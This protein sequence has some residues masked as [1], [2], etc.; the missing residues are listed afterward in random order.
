[1][2]PQSNSNSCVR[3]AKSA[4]WMLPVL[5]L[6]LGAVALVPIGIRASD[7]ADPLNL[8]E[9]ESNI[10]D[11]FFFPKGDQMILILNVRRALLTAA[12]YNLTP[13]EYVVHMDFH[14]QLTFDSDEDRAR[15]GGTVV[16]PAG[17]RPDANLRFRL[18]NDTT[19][20]KTSFEGLTNPDRIRVYT[21]VR[22]DP[23]NFPRFFKRNAISMVMSIPLSSFPEGQ[24]DFILWGTTYKDGKQVDHVGRSNRTQ[25]VRFDP[26]N[27]LPPNEHVPEIMRLMK[28]RNDLFKFFND[29]KEWQPK[30]VAGL[31]QYVYQIRKYDVVPDVMVYTTRFEPKFPNGRQLL[32]DVAALTCQV[33]DCIL[34]E[35]SFIE[36][37]WPRALVNDKPFLADWPYLAEPYPDQPAMP[38]SMKSIW[39][40][41]IGL[42]LANLIVSWLIVEIIVRR[43]LVWLFRRKRAKA[44]A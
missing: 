25:L 8:K 6:L 33:G 14:S 5:I 16:N 1:M 38:Q 17:L 2:T 39:P 11:L 23:F 32:D 18:N 13:F 9:P 10:T 4:R 43:P 31:I 35:L 28:K 15:Y 44:A 36:G 12:P 22:E 37:G 30:A 20:N 26:L 42:L 19:V 41:I 7:H 29:F 24:R 3:K 34:Q 40:Y 21:G 27:T